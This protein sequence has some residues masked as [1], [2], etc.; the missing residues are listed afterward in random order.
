MKSIIYLDRN[1]LSYFGGNAHT[2][3]SLSLPPNTIK[4]AEVIDRIEFTKIFTEW[5]KNNKV[6]PCT[7]SIVLS[8]AY[9]FKKEIPPKTALEDETNLITKF[10]A[11]VPFEK[12]ETKTFPL[13]NSKVIISTNKQILDLIRDSLV[14]ENFIIDSILPLILLVPSESIIFNTETAKNLL[15]KAS[16]LRTMSFLIENQP[17]I[18]NTDFQESLPQE[19]TNSRLFIMLGFLFIGFIIIGVLLYKR[20]RPVK[21]QS[22]NIINPQ[23]VTQPTQTSTPAPSLTITP[24]ATKII[25]IDEITIKIFNG[26]GIPGQAETISK[27]LSEAGFKKIETGNAENS[28]PD[29]TTIIYKK[30][31]DV[32]Y[33]HQINKTI[34][35]F[36]EITSVLEKDDIES[37]VI[38][39][40]STSS[41]S[42]PDK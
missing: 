1:T 2:V 34:S 25:P 24:T 40:T 30:S 7:V 39:T 19:K 9:Y 10:T 13:S 17:I 26:S 12:P 18:A 37:D 6:E 29:K 22:G 23:I 32:E 33:R 35:T 27:K 8:S 38:V 31:V 4:D 15:G 20:T 11:S 21:I 42:S 16:T 3:L 14:A 41:K 5:L 36:D 28:V